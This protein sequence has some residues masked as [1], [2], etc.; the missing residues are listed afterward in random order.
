M[1]S[2]IAIAEIARSFA[3]LVPPCEEW[4]IRLVRRHNDALSVTRGTAD[5]VRRSEDVGA[6]VTITAKS[7]ADTGVG[8]GA[9]SDLTLSGLAAAAQEALAWA[10]RSAGH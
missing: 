3:K 9:T 6:M 7:G 10:K 8:Y 2:L 4:S 5:P 1:N